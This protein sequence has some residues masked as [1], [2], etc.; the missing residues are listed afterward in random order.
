MT[1]VERTLRYRWEWGIDA[2]ALGDPR[3]HKGKLPTVKATPFERPREKGIDLA[4]GLDVVDLALRG[5]LDVAG[6]REL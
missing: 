5:L 4:L 6:H 1:V 3:K 2:D